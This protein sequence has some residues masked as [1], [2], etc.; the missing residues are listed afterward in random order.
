MFGI[1]IIAIWILFFVKI[2]AIPNEDD[3][4]IKIVIPKEMEWQKT[5]EKSGVFCILKISKKILKCLSTFVSHY[6]IIVAR[7][8]WEVL[9]IEKKSRAEYFRERRK[10]RK[11][12]S[13]LLPEEKYKSIDET[14]KQKNKTKTEWLIEKID[15][16][17]KK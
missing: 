17:T 11:A 13:V 15:E 9:K 2:N 10:T 8:S 6:N 16:E 12:F 1:I 3:K 4:H 14:L 5:L 7:Y